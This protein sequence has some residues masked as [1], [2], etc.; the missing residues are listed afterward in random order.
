MCNN[1]KSLAITKNFRLNMKY[2]T[3]KFE[4]RGLGEAWLFYPTYISTLTLS[5][6]THYGGMV[7]HH[8]YPPFLPTTMVVP[9]WATITILPFYPPSQ[10]HSAQL[11]K[12]TTF[13]NNS[14]HR[15]NPPIL[16]EII[17]SWSESRLC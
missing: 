6:Y 14:N 10:A 7:G 8:H 16:Q 12:K 15:Q 9:W 1:F 11:C 3:E 5:L 2:F 17:K 13:L 4:W